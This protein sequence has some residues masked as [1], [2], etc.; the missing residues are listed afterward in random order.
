MSFADDSDEV[1][2]IKRL[3][4]TA[5]ARKTALQSVRTSFEHDSKDIHEMQ[6][7]IQKQ[8]IEISDLMKSNINKDT[9]IKELRFENMRIKDDY[10][11]SITQAKIISSQHKD[12][13]KELKEKLESCYENTSQLNDSINSECHVLSK[14]FHTFEK[15]V[16]NDS[17]ASKNWGLVSRK[18]FEKIK[19]II[20]N[21]SFS[22]A[23]ESTTIDRHNDRHQSSTSSHSRT[24]TGHK[25]K[26]SASVDLAM[27]EIFEH[28]ESE[29]CRLEQMLSTTKSALDEAKEEAVANQIIPH[30]RFAIIRARNQSLDLLKQLLEEKENSKLVKEQLACAYD[31]LRKV[32]ERTH[33]KSSGNASTHVKAKSRTTGMGGIMQR[34]RTE[35]LQK[36]TSQS[37][38]FDATDSDL[39]L[40]YMH[41]S[42]GNK[43]SIENEVEELDNEIENLLKKLQTDAKTQAQTLIYESLTK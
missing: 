14:L 29:N 30:Y 3:M 21:I 37:S 33:D 2:A 8:A 35:G 28:L 5:S 22:T 43:I 13:I 19:A 15:K 25:D 7:L 26:V 1:D 34:D 4:K 9:T 39:P 17:S 27:T 41:R 16:L 11:K 6:I 36:K 18:L 38:I 24:T 32:I 20:K 40:G 10:E 23:N 42:N 12:K 31:E